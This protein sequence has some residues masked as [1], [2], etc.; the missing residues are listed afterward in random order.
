VGLG[1][2]GMS[3][4]E[5]YEMRLRDFFLKLF[6]FRKEQEIDRRENA[7]LIRL[8]TVELLNINLKDDDKIKKTS[9]L[10]KFPWDNESEPVADKPKEVVD[11]QQQ[12]ARLQNLL[13]SFKN[14]E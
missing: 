1:V 9:D 13:K 3:P 5:F 10:W 6:A 11:E 14:H 2:L 4:D 12:S 8:Q 7:E